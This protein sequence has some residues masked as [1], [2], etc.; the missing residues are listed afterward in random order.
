M[1]EAVGYR[2]NS[3]PNKLDSRK[4][5]V[6]SYSVYLL[7]RNHKELG[8]VFAGSGDLMVQALLSHFESS[9]RAALKL[10]K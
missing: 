1:G 5:P 4:G 9:F 3:V 7:V 2:Q 8:C 10:P 6:C